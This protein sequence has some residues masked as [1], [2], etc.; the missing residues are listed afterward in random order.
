MNYKVVETHEPHEQVT[1]QKKSS[2]LQNSTGH[3]YR[4]ALLLRKTR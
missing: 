2:V 3:E 4:S 1:Q